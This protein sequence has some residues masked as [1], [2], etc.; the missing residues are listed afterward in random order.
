ME[1]GAGRVSE[2]A[3]VWFLL[4][5]PVWIWFKAYFG[6]E[7]PGADVVACLSSGILL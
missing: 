2:I 1:G 3:R 4:V 7:G 6:G 5:L